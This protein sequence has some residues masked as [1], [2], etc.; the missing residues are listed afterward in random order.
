MSEFT[1][2]V[3]ATA[4]S[5]P[6]TSSRL[7]LGEADLYKEQL[8][9]LGRKL[10]VALI[11]CCRPQTIVQKFPIISWFPRYQWSYL[12]QDFIAGF[13]VGL[14]TIPQAIA[15]GVVAGLEPQYGLYSAFM[16]CFT[17]IIFG[18]CK[19][20]T[21]A[22]TAIMALMVQPYASISPD[23]AILLCFLAGC[24]ILLLGLCNLGVLVRFISIPV[25]TGEYKL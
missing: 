2:P 16:G 23:Y 21:I 11:T 18:S 22:T 25:I 24:T 7:S 14:T 20:V 10:R 5:V 15:Y 19:D 13:T 6:S 17:Y 1:T 4:V 9:P 3:T 12:L 8:P